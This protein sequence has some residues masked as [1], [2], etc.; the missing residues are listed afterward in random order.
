VFVFGVLPVHPLENGGWVD[1]ANPT[2]VGA[3]FNGTTHLAV[4][5]DTVTA[6]HDEGQTGFLDYFLSNF[7]FFVR[8]PAADSYFGNGYLTAGTLSFSDPVPV[9]AVPEPSS[10]ILLGFGLAGVIAVKSKETGQA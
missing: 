4:T 10:L 9:A 5:G 8:S 6:F 3:P 7:Q 2:N 1:L